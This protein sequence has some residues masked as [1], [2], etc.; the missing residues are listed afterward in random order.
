MSEKQIFTEKTGRNKNYK[1]LDEVTIRFS[2]DSGDGMQLA[3]SQFTLTTGFAGNDLMTFPDFPAEIRAPQN[4]IPG[5]SS[6]QIHFGDH[7]IFTPG[8]TV[9]VL[10]AM[11]PAALKA[12]ISSLKQNGV[13]IANSDEFNERNLI[14]VGYTTNP[15]H[16]ESL[17]QKYRIIEVPISSLTKTAL[18]DTG[19]S[20]K[21]IE[22]SKNFFALGITY[23]LFSRDLQPTI[24]WLRKK[25][26]KKPIY[27]EANIKALMAGHAY[28]DTI[29]ALQERYIIQKAKFPPGVYRNIN[30]NTALALGI[31]SSAILSKMKVLYAGYPIT[32]ASDILHELVKYK[33]CNVYTFQAEDEIAAVSVA[34]G[35]AYGG[36]IGITGSS[37]PGIALKTE[38]INLAVMAELPVV[39]INIQRSGPSTGMPTKTEQA[40]LFQ[41][42]F[43]RNGESP[44]PVLAPATPSENFNLIFEA[45][46]IAV[47]YMTPVFFLSDGYLANGSEPWRLP[48]IEDLDFPIEK[49]S[50]DEKIEGYKV[51]KRDPQTLARKWVIP[52]NV[53]HIHRIGGLE[54]D[55]E[56]KISYD[57]ENH[58]RMVKLRNEKIQRIV[59]DIP[60][61]EVHGHSEGE[62]LVVSWGSTFGCVRTAVDHLLEEGY[63]IGHVH[64]RYLNPF[65]RNLETILKS[66]KK[67]IV[68]EMNLGQLAFILR[69]KY[70][71]PA[72]AYTKVRG[73]P[74]LVEE[75][76]NVF[77]SKF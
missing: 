4:T 13:L 48:N 26:E 15:L 44:V 22:R 29:E 53:H 59:N 14:K 54:K 8:D 21:D 6:F 63:S 49:P 71:V 55:E 17:H 70:L 34:I 24:D 35:A 64:L 66:F 38:A 45:I 61:Q 60:N 42:M 33:H 19:L 76:I 36:A 47:K 31:V 51:Y 74:L 20:A 3:G 2:G 32:P 40:D 30:G 18:Q 72:E 39:I 28:A 41:A 43:G 12:N 46:K 7:K 27:A 50:L 10:V 73:K 75:L 58:D 16:D 77:R 9:D 62:L 11:N 5:V 1:E 67:I 56:G 57:P 69:G 65:P 52:G 68:P 25:F 23:W 37:G